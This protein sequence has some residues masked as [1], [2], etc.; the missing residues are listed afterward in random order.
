MTLPSCSTSAT[1]IVVPI[2][3]RAASVDARSC[4]RRFASWIELDDARLAAAAARRDSLERAGGERRGDLAGLRAA[5]AVGDRE[6]RRLADV[7]VLV[8]AA[9]C[10][11][12]RSLAALA[13]AERSW[14]EPQVGLADADDVARARAGARASG[15][16]RSRTCRSSS[17]C[18]RPRRRRGAARSARGGPRRTRPRAAGRRSSRA[19]ADRERR[20]SRARTRRPRRAPGSRA[21]TSR[22]ELARR[23][24]RRRAL[25]RPPAAGARIIDSCGR[26][27]SRA[28]ERTI[29]QMKR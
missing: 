8:A 25:R 1:V 6:Q 22:P 19:A 14:L 3:E 7:R 16:C 5:H 2:P 12:G 26:R 15:G 23:R 11:R 9:A 17:R 18:P 29:R 24:L 28:A 4:T 13:D 21:T 20:A 27:R 10:G